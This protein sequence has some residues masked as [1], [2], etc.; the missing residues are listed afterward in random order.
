MKIGLIGAGNMSAALANGWA[1]PVVVHD[2]V[3]ERADGLVAQV[4]GEA[5]DSNVAV[6]G[7]ADVVILCHKPAQLADVASEIASTAKCVVS[8]LGSVPLDDVRAAYGDVH[9][10]RVLPNLPVRVRRGV[11]C[12]P[13]ENGA[14]EDAKRVVELFSRV[15]R[16]V[17]LDERLVEPAMAVSS[18]APAFIALVV[19]ALVDAGVR[20]GLPAQTAHGLAVETL[21]G[22]AALLEENGGDTLALR[23]AVTSPGGSTARGLAALEHSGLRAAFDA[24]V[25]AVLGGAR[26]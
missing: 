1:E 12:W 17:T 22:T 9:A 4:G 13:R 16:V 3:A 21:A 8:V 6:A 26:Q 5:L 19:E 10:F 7:A 23:R 18:N 15:G 14:G 24:A 11:L 2:P 20:H 25:Q